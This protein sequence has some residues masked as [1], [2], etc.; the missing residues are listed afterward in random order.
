MYFAVFTAVLLAG[1]ASANEFAKIT[2]VRRDQ[3]SASVLTLQLSVPAK[4]NGARN[5]RVN[6][7]VTNKGKRNVRLNP[8]WTVFDG[9]QS[10]LFSIVTRAPKYANPSPVFIGAIGWHGSTFETLP[11]WKSADGGPRV[12]I[13]LDEE[14][15]PGTI[16]VAFAADIYVGRLQRSSGP[17][18]LVQDG[19][20]RGNPTWTVYFLQ[21]TA[22]PTLQLHGTSWAVRYQASQQYMCVVAVSTTLRILPSRLFH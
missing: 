7:T 16:K 14:G 12:P 3:P 1:A 4:V 13:A 8:R 9:V 18:R 11:G 2:F 15:A 21:C 17:L 20:L 22:W 6:G 5:L 19:R 10:D